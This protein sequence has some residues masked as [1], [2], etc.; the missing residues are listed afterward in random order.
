MKSDI[1]SW[2]LSEA[3]KQALENEA[4]RSSLTLAGLLERVTD[5]WLEARRSSIDEGEQE[6]LRRAAIKWVGVLDG[7]DPG[8][9]SRVRHVVRARLRRRHGR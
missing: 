7:R 5:A 1:Y 6:R 9:S 8:R 4:R 3:K 2:R